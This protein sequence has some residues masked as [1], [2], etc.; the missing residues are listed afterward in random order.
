MRLERGYIGFRFGVSYK[1][2]EGFYKVQGLGVQRFAG[3]LL[4]APNTKP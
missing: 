2:I 4:D 3:I 1:A